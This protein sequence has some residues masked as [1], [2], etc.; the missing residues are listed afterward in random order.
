MAGDK[1]A[2][3]RCKIKVRAKETPRKGTAGLCAARHGG[4]A[5]ERRYPL[6][7]NLA[8]DDSGLASI[9]YVLR[10]RSVAFASCTRISAN[11]APRKAI[12]RL[13]ND[14]RFSPIY[15][16][17]SI[18]PPRDSIPQNQRAIG[19]AGALRFESRIWKEAGISLA[20]EACW[21]NQES[22]RRLDG[23]CL[24]VYA[25]VMLLEIVWSS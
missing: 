6:A 1:N 25:S 13:R 12:K 14:R 10:P 15:S 3:G 22:F 18:C 16:A 24:F 7:V 2:K 20:Y 17:P 5:L 9:S 8:L 23:I 19:A 21:K 11:L 4:K